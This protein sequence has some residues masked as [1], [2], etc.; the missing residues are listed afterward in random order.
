MELCVDNDEGVI[1]VV[2]GYNHRV[3]IIKLPE[4][5]KEKMRLHNAKRLRIESVNSAPPVKPSLIAA[6]TMFPDHN[7]VVKSTE[8]DIAIIAFPNIGPQFMAAVSLEAVEDLSNEGWFQK[9]KYLDSSENVLLYLDTP[10]T[11]QRKTADNK[12]NRQAETFM[13]MLEEIATSRGPDN[14]LLMVAPSLLALQSLLLRGWEPL[15][16]SSKIASMLLDLLLN[17][18]GGSVGD[19]E[20]HALM[21]ACSAMLKTAL[22]LDT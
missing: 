13:K 6:T 16:V 3:Q 8:K 18:E 15:S 7:V 11:T 2:D 10:S 9:N 17:L 5:Q 21:Q 1:I 19:W 4:L 14:S 22:S 12:L 20:K